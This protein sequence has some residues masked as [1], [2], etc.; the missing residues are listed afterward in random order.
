MPSSSYTAKVTTE[1]KKL[2]LSLNMVAEIRIICQ[3]NELFSYDLRYL[4]QDKCFF[5]HLHESEKKKL[6]KCWKLRWT[7]VEIKFLLV[8]LIPCNV[9]KSWGEKLSGFPRKSLQT[10]IRT[11]ALPE[12]NLHV[13]MGQWS[14]LIGNTDVVISCLHQG[15]VWNVIIPLLLLTSAWGPWAHVT[16]DACGTFALALFCPL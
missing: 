4:M 2:E 14:L 3:P 6:I 16:P 1:K 15:N 13:W 9:I 12:E 11:R 8:L 10:F 5:Y 7:E